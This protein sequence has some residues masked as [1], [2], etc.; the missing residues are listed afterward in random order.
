MDNEEKLE[1]LFYILRQK[2]FRAREAKAMGW[3]GL[4]KYSMDAAEELITEI[5]GL[6]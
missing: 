5:E 3:P 6:L 4:F 1:Y 2:V